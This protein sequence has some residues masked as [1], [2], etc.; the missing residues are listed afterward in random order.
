MEAMLTILTVFFGLWTTESFFYRNRHE[1]EIT[2][3]CGLHRTKG[4]LDVF[5]FI[6]ISGLLAF[7]LFNIFTSETSF[8]VV[9]WL[10]VLAFF[11][12]FV[13]LLSAKYAVFL[14]APR[15]C[16]RSKPT[17]VVVPLIFA[18]GFGLLLLLP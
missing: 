16:A 9:S 1:K 5:Q 14:T 4:I 2:R 8:I 15:T 7:S 3:G 10:F 12:S 6:P 18:L 13:V 11:Y 17:V